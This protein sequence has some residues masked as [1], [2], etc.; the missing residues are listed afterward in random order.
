MSKLIERD[1]NGE[2]SFVSSLCVAFLNS[3]TEDKDTLLL[4]ML[5]E[6]SF[7]CGRTRWDSPIEWTHISSR[8]IVLRVYIPQL[9]DFWDGCPHHPNPSVN[10]VGAFI[11]SCGYEVS[12]L[13]SGKKALQVPYE[14]G[15]IHWL[16]LPLKIRE[17][18]GIF[19]EGEKS[20]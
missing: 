6:L 9:C 11:S 8:K 14:D 10:D 1:I 4:E 2:V 7:D 17:A 13:P 3:P 19:L 15:G 18:W 20:I 5:G 12:F 16:K